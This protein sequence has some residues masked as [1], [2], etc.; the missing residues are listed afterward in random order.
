M[1]QNQKQVQNLPYTLME[2]QEGT[3]SKNESNNK[4]LLAYKMTN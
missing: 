3:L 1:G 2:Y 4:D